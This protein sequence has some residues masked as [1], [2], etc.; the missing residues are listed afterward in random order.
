MTVWVPV[1]ASV[2]FRAAQEPAGFAQGPDVGDGSSL[3]ARLR[4]RVKLQWTEIRLQKQVGG[5]GQELRLGRF[6]CMHAHETSQPHSREVG[7]WPHV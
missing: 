3:G 1:A 2:L 4:G 5:Q 6:K 7:K